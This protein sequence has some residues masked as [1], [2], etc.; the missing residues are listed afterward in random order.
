MGSMYPYGYCAQRNGIEAAWT[1]HGLEL[2]WVLADVI[3]KVHVYG[4]NIYKPPINYYIK[5]ASTSNSPKLS[6]GPIISFKRHWRIKIIMIIPRMYQV[7]YDASLETVFSNFI[8]TLWGP[9]PHHSL[10]N[11][12]FFWSPAWWAS[13]FSGDHQLDHQCLWF[14]SCY[15][16]TH[17]FCPSLFVFCWE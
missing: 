11:K 1:S 15:D 17:V 12:I 8:F 10:K 14:P 13:G 4:I 16:V 3:S 2:I 7:E 5:R 9:A 6:F